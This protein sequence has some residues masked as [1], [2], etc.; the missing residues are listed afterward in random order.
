MVAS[1]NDVLVTCRTVATM[2]E[3]SAVAA[4][5]GAPVS[6]ACTVKFDLPAVVGVPAMTP[7]AASIVSPSGNEP[8]LTDH[9]YASV[10]PVATTGTE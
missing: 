5:V 6:M 4:R 3:R 8:A 1:G 2:I 10:P 9:V 7:V